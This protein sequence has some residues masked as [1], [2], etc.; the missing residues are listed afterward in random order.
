LGCHHFFDNFFWA[1]V[2]YLTGNLDN[3]LSFFK[4]VYEDC[5]KNDCLAQLEFEIDLTYELKNKDIKLF[6]DYAKNPLTVSHNLMPVASDKPEMHYAM[7]GE[8]PELNSVFENIKQF[9]P[10]DLPVLII[11]E[12]GTG[13]ELTAQALHNESKRKDKL[14]LAINCGAISESLLQSELFGYE[15][16]AFTGASKF[17]MGILEEAGDGTVFLDEIGEVSP[18]IQ[19]AL[20]RVLENNEIVASLRRQTPI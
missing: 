11:G 17:K 20:L 8:S 2:E 16:G 9:G 1:R 10:L 14:F 15:Q 12:T 5:L 13:K 18:A 6:W 4:T 19:V 3:S 7:L